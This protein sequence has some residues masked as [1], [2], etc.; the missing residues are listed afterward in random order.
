LK[1]EK[2]SLTKLQQTFKRTYNK[3]MKIMS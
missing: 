2:S 3:L 1:E